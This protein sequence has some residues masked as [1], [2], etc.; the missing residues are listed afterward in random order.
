VIN[1]WSNIAR[2]RFNIDYKANSKITFATRIQASYRTENKISD[3][4]VF[5]PAISRIAYL[6]VYNADGTFAPPI[7]GSSNPVADAMLRKNNYD[8]Y[9]GSIYNAI[10]YNFN[11]DLKFTVDANI[12]ANTTH[13]LYFSPYLLTTTTAHLDALNDSMN[14]STFWQ[15]QGFL[16]YNKIIK[17]HSLAG[18]L[19]VSED[20]Q[21]ANNSF[22]QGA[23][24]TAD[25]SVLTMNAT[26]I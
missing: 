15:L 7:A 3:A 12:T 5:E 21:F 4:T 10:T 11:K 19:G 18:V 8:I 14:L 24:L 6:K 16:N 26:G 20:N 1:S 9:N 13:Y 2:G 25:E 23:G 22:Q 17:N